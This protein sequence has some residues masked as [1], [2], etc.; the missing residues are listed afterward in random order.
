MGG[1]TVGAGGCAVNVALTPATINACSALAVAVASTV[2]AGDNGVAVK[3][4]S[5]GLSLPPLLTV[6]V[7]M[8]AGSAG[9][10]NR[11][12]KK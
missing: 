7:A 11:S 1:T 5:A 9:P 2:A 12:P 4:G 8:G 3:V 6:T 10:A